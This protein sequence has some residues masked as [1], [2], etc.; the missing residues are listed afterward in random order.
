[1]QEQALLDDNQTKPVPIPNEWTREG[2]QYRVIKRQGLAVIAEKARQG[3]DRISYEVALLRIEKP[4]EFPP[5]VFRPL[6]E[7]YPTSND[8]GSR[9]WTCMTREQAER[10]F[11]SICE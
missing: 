10:R 3:S 4:V 9:G 5:G 8:W 11:L 2:W 1:M 6:R 7:S